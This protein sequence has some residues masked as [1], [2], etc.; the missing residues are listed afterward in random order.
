MGTTEL[1]LAI[2][3]IVASLGVSL[4][5]GVVWYTARQDAKIELVKEEVGKRTDFNSVQHQK[6]LELIKEASTNI[7]TL[8]CQVQVSADVL[9]QVRDDIRVRYALRDDLIAVEGK[10]E[11]LTI[12]YWKKHG[13][14]YRDTTTN[15]GGSGNPPLL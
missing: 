8:A 11:D 1:I 5:G 10:L 15:E 9:A 7:N 13:S 14:K 4:A 3:A 2:A 6:Q 12:E